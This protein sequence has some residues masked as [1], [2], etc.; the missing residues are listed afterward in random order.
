VDHGTVEQFRL[1]GADLFLRS[2]ISS[3]AGNLSVRVGER[4]IITRHGAML[5]HLEPCSL[6]ELN[7]VGGAHPDASSELEVHRSIY[8]AT[9]TRAVVHAHPPCTLALAAVEPEISPVT[10][11]A[12]YLLGAVLVLSATSEITGTVI[13]NALDSH[14]IVVIRGHGT[15]ARGDSLTEAYAW[16][17][18]LE[19][20]CKVNILTRLME[21]RS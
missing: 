11:E 7:L 10:F 15:F 14:R 1:V 5:G 4:L 12:S 3:H 8:S 9:G 6:V 16:T 2:L 19:E 20:D 17:S 13:A 21:Q 18:S